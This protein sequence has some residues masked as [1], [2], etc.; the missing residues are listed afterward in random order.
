VIHYPSTWPES[1]PV[2][3]GGWLLFVAAGLA[4]TVLAVPY[5]FY[6]DWLPWLLD[7]ETWAV[8]ADPT[9]Y[10]YHPSF[11]AFVLFYL[12]V[13]ALV[14]FASAVGLVLFARRSP[15]FPKYM[16]L[17]YLGS[18]VLL[19]TVMTVELKMW[20]Y[21]FESHSGTGTEML[22]RFFWVLLGVP[23]IAR[24]R[25]VKNTFMKGAAPAEA[26]PHPAA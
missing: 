18:F 24:S 12:L 17:Y 15:E 26:S 14:G 2:G 19:V 4:H 23:Y 5:G 22:I 9:A 21:D 16:I 25:R 6:A 11:P 7:P 3:R 13:I 10:D 20:P 1:G 8:F